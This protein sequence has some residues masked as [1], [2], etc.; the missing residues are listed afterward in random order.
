M[1]TLGVMDTAGNS[2]DLQRACALT[3]PEFVVYFYVQPSICLIGFILNIINCQI[4][5]KPEFV[6][7]AYKLMIALSLTDAITLI[8][9]FPLGFQR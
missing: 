1:P 7:P 5:R 3:L 6:G 4:F 8:S 2:S 9:T